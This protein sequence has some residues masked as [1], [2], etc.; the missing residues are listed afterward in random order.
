VSRQ[1]HSAAVQAHLA[2][3]GS[4]V[5]SET[6]EGSPWIV[7]RHDGTSRP[8]APLAEV[9]AGLPAALFASASAFALGIEDQTSRAGLRA[10]GGDT[11]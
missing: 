8:I 11:P 4:A 9:G 7:L 1:P 10:S 2:K 6:H 5:I 3:Q